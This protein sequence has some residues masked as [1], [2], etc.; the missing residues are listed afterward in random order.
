[1]VEDKN[2]LSINEEITLMSDFNFEV[3]IDVDL[4]CIFIGNAD[5]NIKFRIWAQLCWSEK[6]TVLDGYLLSRNRP[7]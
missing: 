7:C 3:I 5:K 1:M 6:E 2:V 4:K